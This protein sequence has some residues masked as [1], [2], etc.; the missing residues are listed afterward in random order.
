[1]SA[2]T[3]QVAAVIDAVYP[4]PEDLVFVLLGDAALIRD[5]VGKYGPLVEMPITAP[6]F[7]PPPPAG[8]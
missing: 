2:D 3:G 4:T 7:R 1:M 8:E 6:H 5:Q